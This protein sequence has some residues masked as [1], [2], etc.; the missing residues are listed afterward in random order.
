M[1]IFKI[2]LPTPPEYTWLVLDIRL[3]SIKYLRASAQFKCHVWE[4]GRQQHLLLFVVA[5]Q[6]SAYCGLFNIETGTPTRGGKP[7]MLPKMHV[8]FVIL[9]LFT[10][11][12]TPILYI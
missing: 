3:W 11:T 12:Y 7:D 4:I 8:L 1:R 5:R 9:R 6:W 2:L 10:P